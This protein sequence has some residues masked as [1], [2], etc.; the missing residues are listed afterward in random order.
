MLTLGIHGSF[1]QEHQ[2]P[3]S[4][5]LHDSAAA[6]LKDGEIIAAIEEERLSRV[7]HTSAFPFRAIEHC[8]QAAGARISDC[9]IIA[10]N[11]SE[12]SIAIES[13]TRFIKD[14]LAPRKFDRGF[15]ARLLEERFGG[16]ALSEKLRF[17]SHHLAHAW[18]A[19]FLSGFPS[20]LV[21][22]L[23]GGGENAPGPDLSGLIGRFDGENFE[24]LCEHAAEQRS[25]GLWY[26]TAMTLLGYRLFDEY[27]V[28]GL[29]PYGRPETFEEFASS[30]YKLLPEGDFSLASSNPLEFFLGAQAR[31]LLEQARRK[32]EPLTQAH[33]DLACALQSAVERVILHIVTHF[34]AKTGERSLC[35]AGGVAQN[36][37]ANG[38]LL[39]SRMFDRLFVQPAAYDAGGAL[40]AALHA[41]RSAGEPIRPSRLRHVFLGTDATEHADR[42]AAELR[43]WSPLIRFETAGED[44][45]QRTAALIAAGK[46][47]GWVQGKS[48][49]GP[50]ALGNR[51][52]VA[53]P[54]PAANKDRVNAMVKKREGY[55]PFAPSV[56]E[57]AA[58][59]FF[60]LPNQETDLS[61]MTFVVRVK[62][63]ERQ[64][65]GATTHV[66]GT[67]RIQTV[68][69]GTNPRFHKLIAEFGKLTGIPIL[70]NTSF[71]NDAEPIVD[72]ARDAIATY[73]T[74]GLDALVIGNFLVFAKVDLAENPTA[75]LSLRVAMRPSRRLVR[76]LA[77]DGRE[78]RC[79]IDIAAPVKDPPIACSDVMFGILG[80]APTEG[81]LLSVIDEIGIPAS[82]H[83]EIAREAL[84]LWQRRAIDL[85]P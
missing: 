78:A 1:A 34:H 80:R 37:S 35:L 75:C 23:D 32:G 85:H 63:T 27:K 52:I 68:G 44:C 51:S 5:W 22:C 7:K 18:S 36:S 66:D 21:V 42:L 54:R 50:R 25:I 19:F 20:S 24:M 15:L 13:R 65:L 29:A 30:W 41:S 53:D 60:E 61:F 16:P 79:A 45:E 10:Y 59:R 82:A 33:R 56:L 70:L 57:E 39:Y 72:S 67:A 77:A 4:I 46:I 48:E 40:G 17:C 12:L 38:R 69:A 11:Q 81:T 74:T 62:E 83:A 26:R 47:V 28:M 55:R 73:L 3:E 8:L 76:T 84:D 2:D 49:F 64:R 9:D 71:N 14:P 58:D 31:G 6:I 43:S